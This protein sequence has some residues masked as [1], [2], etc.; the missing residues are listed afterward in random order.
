MT[1]FESGEHAVVARN[2]LITQA[3]ITA[4]LRA[5]GVHSGM[6]LLV[7]TAMSQLGWVCG[8]ASAVI[9]ALED[10]VGE[11][12]TLMM[13]AHSGDLSDPAQWHHPPVPESWWQTIRDT[14]PA[15]QPDLT[16]TR[17]MGVVA[18]CFRKQTGTRRSNHP[19][20]SFAARGPQAEFLTAGHALTPG[21]G[22][23]SPLARLYDLDGW[24]LLLGVGHGNNT[25]LHLA[26]VRAAF[27]D[28][29]EDRQ[30]A[31]VLVNGQRQWVAFSD[32]AYDDEDFPQIGAAF[33]TARPEDVRRGQ[34]GAA[35]VCLLRQ[36]ALVDFGA[37]WM[38]QHRGK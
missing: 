30:G 35:R 32:L 14:M 33:E 13:P 38:T 8:G 16:H 1:E 36:R 19:Q 24:V 9:L 15:F 25:S 11:G 28:K 21:M 23:G 2:T 17:G 12:G 7:H 37:N 4:G 26:E 3:E 34:I 18:E 10:A 20:V 22:E 31:P 29:A 5:V 6:T 27:P